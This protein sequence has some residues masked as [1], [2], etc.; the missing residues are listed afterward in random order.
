MVNSTSSVFYRSSKAYPVAVRAEGPYLWDAAG[1]QYLDGSSGALVANIG[2]GRAEV[3][4][5][6]ARR[7]GP[8]PSFT[9]RSFPARCW[10]N[11]RR[12]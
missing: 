5:A 6:M 2:Q 10:R 1:K 4:E 11:T 9:A 7:R 8:W 12:G 3:A